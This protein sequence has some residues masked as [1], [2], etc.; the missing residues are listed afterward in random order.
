MGCGGGGWVGMRKGR[1]VRVWVGVGN[2][3]ERETWH[4]RGVGVVV[5]FTFLSVNEDA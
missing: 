1:E 3:C 4:G 5:V 2:G